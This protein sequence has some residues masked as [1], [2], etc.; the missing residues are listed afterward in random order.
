MRNIK[1]LLEYDGSNYYGWQKQ[2][3]GKTIQ[4]TIEKAIWDLTKE[5]INLIGCSRTDSGVHS[6]GYIA[7]FNENSKIPIDRYAVALNQKLP[8]DIVV[9]NAQ[10]V[11][12]EFH[13]RYSCKGKTYSYTIMNRKI[14]SPLLKNYC[15]HVNREIDLNKMISASKILIGKHD[16][17]AFMNTGSIVSS[18]IRTISDIEINK[19]GEL[20][21]LYVTGDGFLYNMVRIITGTLIAIGTG[22]KTENVLTEA[23]I[24]KNRMLLGK[25]A[26][27]KGLCLEKVYY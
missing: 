22:E 14:R 17:Q 5:K 21:K 3:L 1:L 15:H 20:I 23:F 4:G 11:E 13:S 18:T 6:R 25:T 7:N 19:D 2:N 12:D 9:L 10:E 27:G 24:E 26:P 16:F 8:I